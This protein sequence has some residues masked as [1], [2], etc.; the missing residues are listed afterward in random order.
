MAITVLATSPNVN[1]EAASGVRYVADANGFFQNVALA[2]V[3]DMLR[4]GYSITGPNGNFVMSAAGLIYET[5]QIGITAGATRTL[6]GAYALTREVSRIDVTTAPA[7]GVLVGDGVSL[8]VAALGGL[9]VTVINNTANILTV[10]PATAADKIN[11]LAAGAGVPIPAGDVAHFEATAVNPTDWRFDPGMG[12]AGQLNT[13]LSNDFITATGTTQGTAVV[14]GGDINR[15]TSGTGGVILPAGVTGLD[16]FVI[17]HTGG[18]IQVYSNGTDQIDDTAGSVGLSQM[19][20]SMCLYSCSSA[21]LWYSNGI[22]TG[23]AGAYPTQSYT[24]AMTAFAGGGQASA[25]MLATVLNRLTTVATINDSV[26]LPTAVAGMTV[27]VLNASPNSANVFPATG[28]AINAGAAN[29][30]FAVAGGKTATFFTT[31]AGF[32]H[33]MLSA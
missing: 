17:N 11:G 29:A 9:D 10:Y 31:I 12:A 26:R 20:G 28:D 5:V 8:P 23:Y 1:F 19:N 27:T 22:G 21:G 30:A 15:V 13:V 6:A 14:L 3:I 32:W 24:N 33:S 18:P 4:A 7:A 16:M 25:T 2:D